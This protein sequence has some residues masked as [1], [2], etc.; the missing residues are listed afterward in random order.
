MAITFS[1]EGGS[2]VTVTPLPRTLQLGGGNDDR[3]GGVLPNVRGG[4][5][6]NG[7]C[8]AK[9][10]DAGFTLATAI[11]LCSGVGD[12]NVTVSGDA[13]SYGALVDVEITG[14]V[15]QKA[16]ISWKGSTASA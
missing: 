6:M 9:I 13:E 2:P 1:P 8:E 11:A 14:N 4:V 3:G 12:G 15:I 10:E 7:S 5:A 16:K